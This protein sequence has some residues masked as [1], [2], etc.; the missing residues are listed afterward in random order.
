M[1][2]FDIRHFSTK[3]NIS[4]YMFKKKLDKWNCLQNKKYVKLKRFNTCVV[5][6]WQKFKPKFYLVVFFWKPNRG[7]L[8]QKAGIA[9]KFCFRFF[10]PLGGKK[11]IGGKIIQNA[12]LLHFDY[13]R[14][15]NRHI[16]ANDAFYVFHEIF[17]F[18]F[19]FRKSIFKYNGIQICWLIGSIGFGITKKNCPIFFYNQQMLDKHI[20]RIREN[21]STVEYRTQI[22]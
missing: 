18:H 4:I 3:Q 15:Q 20:H 17:P 7:K 13:G 9:L 1:F 11:N 2:L 22:Q 10:T 8:K 5:G 21:I 19:I 14:N 6:Q 12:F 16:A